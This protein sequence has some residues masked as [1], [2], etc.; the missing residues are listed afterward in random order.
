MADRLP[1]V[2]IAGEKKELPASDTIAQ[3]KINSLVGDLALKAPLA[4]PVFTGASDFSAGG[5]YFGTAAAANL[6]DD[7]EEGTWTPVLTSDSGE[8]ATLGA[9]TCYYTKIGR[10]VTIN[11]NELYWSAIS[12]AFTSTVRITGLPFTCASRG[13]GAFI[14]TGISASGSDTRIVALAEVSQAYILLATQNDNTGTYGLSPVVASSGVIFGLQ[15]TYI[16]S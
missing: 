16:V 13:G 15:V 1:I 9:Y 5:A 8:T 11:I 10:K 4:S 7:Y 2:S 3:S 12:G 14:N 6:L